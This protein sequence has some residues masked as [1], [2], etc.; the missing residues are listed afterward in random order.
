LV[1]FHE[2]WYG[3]NAIERDLEAIIFNPMASFHFILKLMSLKVVR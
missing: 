1:E 3:G 2:L